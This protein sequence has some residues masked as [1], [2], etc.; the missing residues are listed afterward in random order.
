MARVRGRGT[1]GKV[2]VLLILIVVLIFIGLFLFDYLNLI[3][4]KRVFSPIYSMFGIQKPVGATAE[5]DLPQRGNLD[6]DRYA[7]R[8][9]SLEI[10]K[11]ELAQRES[12]L[13]ALEE[14]NLKISAQLAEERGIIEEKEKS[15]N[16]MLTETNNRA[17]SIRQIA[18]YMYQMRPKD[19]VENILELDDQDIIDIFR[20]VEKYSKS[21][22]KNSP[23]SYWFSLM[24][25]ERAADIQRK[26]ANNPEVLP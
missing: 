22:G 21:Q 15:F 20:D 2:I 3:N 8:L 11:E 13:K 5:T 16:M 12:E 17:A 19:A 14:E 4:A 18:I 25:P 23:V 10:W 9:E 6:E 26:M 24:P 7:K 1:V